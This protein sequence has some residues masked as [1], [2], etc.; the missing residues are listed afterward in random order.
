MTRQDLHCLSVRKW[1]RLQ[2][3]RETVRR[4]TDRLP[5]RF[6]RRPSLSVRE[7]RRRHA[8]L[9]ID[10]YRRRQPTGEVRWHWPWFKPDLARVYKAVGLKAEAA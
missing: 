2:A 1:N 5:P 3:R 4:G 9:R 6:W 7:W 10:M 8:P